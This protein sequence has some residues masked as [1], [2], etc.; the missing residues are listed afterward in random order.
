MCFNE[1]IKIF[2]FSYKNYYTIQYQGVTEKPIW[3]Q[4][5]KGFATKSNDYIYAVIY[6]IKL[7]SDETRE[8]WNMIPKTLNFSK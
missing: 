8:A 5:K 3:N 7:A 4:V 6:T 1:Y 2:Q